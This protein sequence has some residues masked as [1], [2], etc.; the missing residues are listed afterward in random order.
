VVARPCGFK[1]HSRHHFL[2]FFMG[3]G[4]LALLAPALAM[5]AVPAGCISKKKHEAA[6]AQVRIELRSGAVEVVDGGDDDDDSAEVEPEV[7]VV[8]TRDSTPYFERDGTMTYGESIPAEA[9]YGL[10]GV[11]P[12]G[13]PGGVGLDLL[14]VENKLAVEERRPFA[15]AIY[16]TDGVGDTTGLGVA[17]DGQKLLD[18]DQVSVDESAKFAVAIMLPEG[19]TGRVDG[20]YKVTAQLASWCLQDHKDSIQDHDHQETDPTVVTDT[21]GGNP[22]WRTWTW[23]RPEEEGLFAIAIGFRLAHPYHGPDEWIEIGRRTF[24][25]FAPFV[26]EERLLEVQTEDLEVAPLSD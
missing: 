2:T 7:E 10:Y 24:I 26:L 19:W 15:Y 3:F 12:D 5:L 21:P 17:M 8:E 1:S 16:R 9:L 18:P 22:K 25:A 13:P 14:K 20:D 4:R 6:L 11:R 23:C